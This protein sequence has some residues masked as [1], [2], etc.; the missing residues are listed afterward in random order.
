M[1]TV[2][3]EENVYAALKNNEILMD[4]LAKADESIFHL[5]APEVFPDLPLLVYSPIDDT[6]IL[7]G[8]NLEKLHSV[9]MR[10]HIVHGEY[11]YSQIYSEVKKIMQALDFTRVNTTP[12]KSHDGVQMLITDFEI[13]TGG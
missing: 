11:D 8:D 4:L 9:T 6:P 10:I 1:E 5:Q 7:H 13:I 12:Y 3:I 2:E